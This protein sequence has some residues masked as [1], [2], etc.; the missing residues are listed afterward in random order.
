MQLSA[1]AVPTFEQV[2]GSLT[3]ILDKAA[4][5]A[6]A[7]K[8]DPA[9]LIGSRLAPDMYPLSRQVQLVSDF[10]KGVAARLGG[11]EMPR[12]ADDETTIDA[13]KA[14]LAKTL[15]FVRS[16]DPAAIDAAADKDV[17]FPA[18]PDR[19]RTLKGSVYFLHYALP[20]F[21]FHATTAYDI[22]R[23]NGIEIG[24]RDFIGQIPGA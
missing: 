12:Y 6:A 1:I 17:S 22:L 7:K 15:A 4:A 8:I 18:G 23:H 14:R 13:L 2:I 19:T 11:V 5:H 24:K 9:V 16:I 20:Q 3:A 21:Y 10:A